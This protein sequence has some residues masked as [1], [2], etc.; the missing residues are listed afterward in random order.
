MIAST[1]TGADGVLTEM[2]PP[3]AG[4]AGVT[5]AALGTGFEFV[6][7]VTGV[8]GALL[9]AAAAPAGLAGTLLPT[10]A[11]LASVILFQS[12]SKTLMHSLAVLKW[13][14]RDAAARMGPSAAR[15]PSSAHRVDHLLRFVA[16]R[17][18]QRPCAAG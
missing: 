9:G 18:R 10:A 12:L 15:R 16:S 6:T 13:K 4:A 3:A 17:T 11:L 2:V 8:S 14:N 5:G 1:S 7:G